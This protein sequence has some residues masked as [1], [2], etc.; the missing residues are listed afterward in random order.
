MSNTS[1]RQRAAAACVLLATIATLLPAPTH[2][3]QKK[4]VTDAKTIARIAGAYT[5]YYDSVADAMAAFNAQQQQSF[6]DCVSR[7]SNGAYQCSKH[8]A[9][10][11]K[12]WSWAVFYDDMPSGWQWD[13]EE[14]YTEY[15]YSD[16]GGASTHAWGNW[17]GGD[18]F[19][20]C[21]TGWSQQQLLISPSH[22]DASC[23]QYLPD[24]PDCDKCQEKGKP[25]LAGNPVDTS[26][27]V[28]LH[29]EVDYADAS[30]RLRFT[31]RYAS[32]NGGWQQLLPTIWDPIN[33]ALGQVNLAAACRKGLIPWSGGGVRR[34]CLPE[35]VEYQGV[36]PVLL[37]TA[38]GAVIRF[39][40][41]G[42]G[43]LFKPSVDSRSVLKLI[44]DAGGRKAWLLI[45][46]SGSYDKFSD[47]G[48]LRTRTWPSG[49]SVSYSYV[50][51]KVS[52]ITDY[53]GRSIA[54]QYTGAGISQ[55][56]RPDGQ[57]I[58]YS[59]PSSDRSVT[60]YPDGTSKTFHFGQSNLST[61]GS[62]SDAGLF[63]G[64][65][66]ERGIRY[67]TYVYDTTWSVTEEY[68]GNHVQHYAFAKYTTFSTVA[69]PLN[70]QRY[71][72]FED[73]AAGNRRLTSQSQPAGSGSSSASQTLTYDTQGN[74]ASITDFTNNRTCY[75]YDTSRNL[76]TTRV[77]GL[78][79]SQSC[80]TYTPAGA[81]LPSGVRKISTERHPDYG[82]AVR[83]AEASRMT[84][85]VYN[86][87]PD[88]F[89]SGAIA[90][91]APADALLP[92]GKPIAVLCK[93]VEQATTDANGAS[94]FNAGLQAGVA[95]REWKWTY[96][97]WGQVLSEDGPRTD[98]ADI[99][100]YTYY[101]DTT[102]D[103]TVGDL[104]SI[105]NAAGQL[106]QFTKYNAH[107]QLLESTDAKGVTTTHTYDLRLRR[108][109]TT[110]GERTTSYDYEP[111]GDLKRI[112]Q[113]DGS[114]IENTY[115]DARRIV[116]VHD[117]HGNQIAYTLDNAGNRTKED[118]K[119]PMGA[120]TRQINRSFDALSRLKQ[121]TGA[122]N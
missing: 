100:T 97:R 44:D 98:V 80:T 70:A 59:V 79:S 45:A 51:G 24:P 66:D 101:A 40:D 55:I 5:V 27:G 85:S 88:P 104:Q 64:I 52:E 89:A 49:A 34:V 81:T 19:F 47:D 65:T 69:D 67:A 36:A 16:G 15:R 106:T 107:G 116:A 1:L 84:T 10:G 48:L 77:E 6:Q 110:I 23:Y 108:T 14:N 115:D 54:I 117:S 12:P 11:W 13:P 111:T 9:Y 58:T 42:N 102:A 32:R 38:H 41:T 29:T 30:G 113:P 71:Y 109:S 72:Y 39:Y 50:D 86:G 75:T 90:S 63:T 18:G 8:I 83:I 7:A 62:D 28:K 112:T 3:G 103:H 92:D 74:V 73:D 120:L 118:V 21:P 60:S 91:C 57:V 94:R 43:V 4:A 2:A 22:Y 25:P 37:R 20:T 114:W 105:T 96:N 95:A 99:T 68:H 31:R 76:E 17:H 78:T 87:Q 122:T 35:V 61:P 119:D 93:R 46:E 53:S 26:T 121:V 56:T 82:F 33:R